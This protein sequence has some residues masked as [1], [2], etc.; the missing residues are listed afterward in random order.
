MQ[1]RESVDRLFT[2]LKPAINGLGY[3]L[4]DLKKQ[5]VKGTLHIVVVIFSP[6]GIGIEDCSEVHNT[7]LPKIELIEDKRDIHLEVSSP[8]IN[9]TLK[10]ADE[11]G[12]FIDYNVK[13]LEKEASDWI[14]GSIYDVDDTSVT[15]LVREKTRTIN[16]DRIQKA[17]LE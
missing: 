13:I 16:F 14:H 1:K 7:I 10:T 17:K 8:G 2:L 12:V 9:R 5:H 3:R 15:L 6:A 11:F 4:V